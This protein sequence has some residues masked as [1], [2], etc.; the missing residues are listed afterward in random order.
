[1]FPQTFDFRLFRLFHGDFPARQSLVIARIPALVQRRL[2]WI[3]SNVHFSLKDA[4]KVRFHHEHG[5]SYLHAY[6][7]IPTIIEGDYYQ[8]PR[9]GNDRTLEV[10]WHNP[11]IEKDCHFLVLQRNREDTGIF[12]RTFYRNKAITRSK[13]SGSTRLLNQSGLNYFKNIV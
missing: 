3:S 5:M 7:I 11:A 9:R 1:V 12:I 6:N 10:V 8:N 2:G 4:Q 13:L